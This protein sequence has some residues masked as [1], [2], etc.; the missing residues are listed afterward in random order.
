MPEL[1]LD[2]YAALLLTA[3]VH[4]D[5]LFQLWLPHDLPDGTSEDLDVPITWQAPANNNP[6]AVALELSWTRRSDGA[7]G[8]E[9]GSVSV[10]V[11]LD[12]HASGGA[13][14][15]WMVA[16]PEGYVHLD[17]HPDQARIEGLLS[18]VLAD[19]MPGC[20]RFRADYLAMQGKAELKRLP[21]TVSDGTPLTDLIAT[22]D[23]G[24]RRTNY[25]WFRGCGEL[26]LE[27]FAEWDP[28]AS[29]ARGGLMSAHYDLLAVPGGVLALQSPSSGY[30]PRRVCT[31]EEYRF[32]GEMV[33]AILAL[34]AEREALAASIAAKP[35][36]S[37][38]AFLKL[39]GRVGRG[40]QLKYA[41][42]AGFSALVT[43]DPDLGMN[44]LLID[45][46]R[47]ALPWPDNWPE[48]INRKLAV[49]IGWQGTRRCVVRCASGEAG[50]GERIQQAIDTLC[51]EF[52]IDP[53]DPS[54]VSNAGD[55]LLVALDF[56]DAVC[57]LLMPPGE[58]FTPWRQN[59][60][61][62]R[63]VE[64]KRPLANAAEAAYQCFYMHDAFHAWP[65]IYV[66]KDSDRDPQD[67][68]VDDF[69]KALDAW[70]LTPDLAAL[71]ASFAQTTHNDEAYD[72]ICNH[73]RSHYPVRLIIVSDGENETCGVLPE[74]RAIELLALLQ[75]FD[76]PLLVR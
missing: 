14:V 42:G 26:A 59:K 31:P 74:A 46:S 33:D 34:Q 52:D 76:L 2:D 18:R 48:H 1:S 35:P 50:M 24:F 36:L 27:W 22:A 64:R 7:P 62:T 70:G 23:G 51:E 71:A 56:L 67:A 49:W 20:L 15:R 13:Q 10:E 75:E 3:R 19:L 40:A 65:S 6:E 21:K 38:A 25:S 60:Q 17:E 58:P 44:M 8:G 39:C 61:I 29:G 16:D 63:M 4:K 12:E 5:L 11:D 41:D 73:V 54:D 43:G 30:P 69:A 45:W 68:Y 9:S 57:A 47:N 55:Q 53:A 28:A 66:D 72:A 37:P 32:L